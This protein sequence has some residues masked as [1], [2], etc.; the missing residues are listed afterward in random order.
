MKISKI[1]ALSVIF[2][3][4]LTASEPSAFGAGDLNNPTPYGLSKT[5]STLLETKK[6]LQK[7][8]A[9]S[10][11]QANQVDS[12]RE[13]IDG[14]QSVLESI[15]AANYTNKV[16]LNSIEEK[17]TQDIKNINEYNKRLSE[18]LEEHDRLINDNKENIAKINVI[19][20]EV[21]KIVDS[22]NSSYVSKSEFNKL[23]S[24]V[25]RLKGVSSVG[26][27][28]QE[29]EPPQKNISQANKSNA[30]LEKDAALA[31][32]NKEYKKAKEIYENLAQ[33]NY[34]PAKAHYMIGEIDYYAKS[35][36]SAISSYKKS[37]TLNDKADYMPVLL[38]HTAIS[39]DES[40]DKANAQNFYQAL[41]QKYPASA[42]AKLAAKKVKK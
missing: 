3:S 36:N 9:K 6:D 29:K 1:I 14:I 25:N 11:N 24:D 18:T 41:I 22:I 39:M 4:H 2:F 42:E 32:K 19:L 31:Y 23:V 10:N 13:R 12:L 33:N 28:A 30:D 15:S 5:E 27:N 16:K 34:K 8:T 37:A 7:V 40:G 35:Y 17:G 20:K 38:L 21:S 26:S